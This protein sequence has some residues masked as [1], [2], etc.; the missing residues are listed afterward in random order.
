MAPGA[1]GNPSARLLILASA[2][3]RRHALLVGLGLEPVVVPVDIDETPRDGETPAALAE[4]L[5][6]AKAAAPPV[7]RSP[8]LVLAADTVVAV[9]G[10]VLGKPA[11][12]EE[13]R[14]MIRLLA[15]RAHEVIT[16]LAVR[17]VP[18]EIVTCDRVRSR[19]V[20]APMTAEEVAW[21]AATGEGSDKAGG[22]ALQGIGGLF[23]RAIEGSYTNVI[24]LPLETLYP[25]LRRWS[26][27]PRSASSR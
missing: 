1:P 5:A 2:S 20:F 21:Y 15:G 10:A 23:V 18:E 3:P 12:A 11:G 4:R 8:A 27:L 16:A 17:A 22:Y 25:H 24:G 9:D 14:R 26:I 19:V 7:P 6:R 13:A